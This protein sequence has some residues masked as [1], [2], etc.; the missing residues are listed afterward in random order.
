MLESILPHMQN[1]Y[2]HLVIELR[3][4]RA[5]ESRILLKGKT[6]P[7]KI[8]EN[9]DICPLDC[10]KTIKPH[11]MLLTRHHT[12]KR[13]GLF[14]CDGCPHLIFKSLI[15]PRSKAPV[16]TEPLTQIDEDNAQKRSR[17]TRSKLTQ[18]D[19]EK[20][21]SLMRTYQSKSAIAKMLGVNRSAI[22]RFL[23]KYP[24]PE[25][26]AIEQ[27]VQD[28]SEVQTLNPTLTHEDYIL[29]SEKSNAIFHTRGL[30]LN[31]PKCGKQIEVGNL[32]HGTQANGKSKKFYHKECWESL[33][34]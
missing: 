13:L 16:S 24:V 9:P 1:S 17:R 14:Y 26:F 27:N 8:P 33:F 22:R 19:T 20:I 31:C 11:R 21:W 29:L 23:R 4:E 18:K 6:V 2:R 34:N 30:N 32:Y 5:A 28:C 10:K 12:D 3:E 7:N 25:T 15:V